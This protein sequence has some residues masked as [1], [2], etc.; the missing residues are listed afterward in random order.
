MQG[1][2]VLVPLVEFAAAG[3]EPAHPVNRTV[4]D[5]VSVAQ[6]HEE[7]VMLDAPSVPPP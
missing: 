6:V 5:M 4:R 7:K 3:I 2:L 1:V